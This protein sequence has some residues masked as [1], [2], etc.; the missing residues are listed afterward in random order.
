MAGRCAQ[1]NVQC[2]VPVLVALSQNVAGLGEGELAI[3]AQ[4]VEPEP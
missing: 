3:A 2:G 1:G 4:L